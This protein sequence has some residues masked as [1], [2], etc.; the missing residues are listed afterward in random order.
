MTP[1][2]SSRRVPR[3]A[4]AGL[5]AGT[6]AVGALSA[7]TPPWSGSGAQDAADVLARGL[8]R[9]SLEDVA[10]AGDRAAAQEQ[11][12]AVVADLDLL[13]R[14]QVAVDEVETED[15]RATARLGWRWSVGD[16][17]WSYDTT[18]RLRRTADDTW[19]VGWTP[20]LVEPSL[21]RGEVLDARPVTARRGV[22]SGAGG[23]V[24]VRPR[25]V[26]RVGVGKDGLDDEAAAGAARAVAEVVDV[27]PGPYVEQVAAAGP[28]AFVEAIV[29]R[30]ADLDDRQRSALEAV[31]GALLVD[32]ELPL[33]P[34]RDFAAPLLGTV[35]PATAEVVD[36][37]DGEVVPGDEVGLSGLQ[38]RYDAELRGTRG[39]EVSAAPAD[40]VVASEGRTLLSVDPVPGR[41]LRTTLDQGLQE[42]AQRVLADVGPAS[43]L[44]AVRPSTGDLLAV[45]SGPGGGGLGTATE[46]RY[47]PGSTFK[48]VTSLALLRAGL[49]PASAVSCPPTLT[50]DGK[51]F[52][53]Y[54]DY[55]ADATGQI[56]LEDAV[57]SSCNT[58]F[59]GAGDELGDGDL[60]SAAA[61]LGL[62][63]DRDLGF[64]AYLGRVDRSGTATQEAAALIG[65]GT[66]LASPLAM[67]TVVASVVRGQVVVP[68]LLP[69]LESTATPPAAPL[70]DREA[71]QLR[72]MLGAVV[73]R[74]S[75]RLL[76]D[77]PGQ[78]VIAKTG[79]AEFGDAE[80]LQTHAWMVAG[81]G[82]LA[83]AVF[84]E[85]GASGSQTAG[86]VLRAFLAGAPTP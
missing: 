45:A 61:A 82:D 36:A 65:Q 46:G 43:A 41:P 10:V 70:T 52:E 33:A 57:A 15:D 56:T 11:L 74:G 76:A 77:L 32:D 5:L 62:G 44:V 73:E 14:P 40:A 8:A 63:V 53:N 7:C 19:Q 72:T 55:P 3:G 75:G 71:A 83:V 2:P 17:V 47:A 12:A 49:T 79:T 58:A 20:A 1:I 67:A 78:P 25:P 26:V 22:I 60:A 13:G 64:P 66:V 51:V 4:L 30:A 16:E 38:R 68:R 18:A 81:R 27:A 80:P 37:S 54:D 35:G 24:L 9:G 28:R 23:Q 42:Q 86:P 59:I 48:V 29:L 34:T 39:V 84:V 85:E 50:V 31:D 69:G 6:L 21:E